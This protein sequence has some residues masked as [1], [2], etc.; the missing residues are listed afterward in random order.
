MWLSTDESAP[1]SSLPVSGFIIKIWDM[2]TFFFF[3]GV[4]GSYHDAAILK[5]Y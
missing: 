2:A 1:P 4:V 3:I 5:N